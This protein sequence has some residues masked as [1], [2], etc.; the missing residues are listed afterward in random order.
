[1]VILTG[2]SSVTTDAL[3]DVSIASPDR[4]AKVKFDGKTSGWAIVAVQ[5]FPSGIVLDGGDTFRIILRGHY[6]LVADS[7]GTFVLVFSTAK[8]YYP[9]IS[10]PHYFQTKVKIRLEKR[11]G[12]CLGPDSHIFHNFI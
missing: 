4:Q 2:V 8:V 9:Q 7:P 1:M 6:A 3:S 5:A 11:K 12:T 10:S